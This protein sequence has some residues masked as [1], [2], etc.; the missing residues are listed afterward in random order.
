MGTA[1][2]VSRRIDHLVGEEID[3]LSMPNQVL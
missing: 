2:A 3:A 1:Y